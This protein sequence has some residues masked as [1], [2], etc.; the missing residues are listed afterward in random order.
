M[1]KLLPNG[2]ERGHRH[3][4][5]PER[6]AFGNDVPN[7]NQP[8]RAAQSRPSPSRTVQPADSQRWVTRGRLE[9]GSRP[10]RQRD[11]QEPARSSVASLVREHGTPTLVIH[12]TQASHILHAR[13]P[14]SRRES[15]MRR[16]KIG[17][18]G[19]Q[20]VVMGQAGR[21][22]VHTPII[23]VC[24]QRESWD[25]AMCVRH[26]AARAWDRFQAPKTASR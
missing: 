19:E 21:R 2:T 7:V 18:V 14:E 3:D 16:P 6:D 9:R 24:R 10:W 5:D 26:I 11:R 17:E 8:P 15:D 12:T 25:G 20:M 23:L 22:K 13:R 4:C 1:V